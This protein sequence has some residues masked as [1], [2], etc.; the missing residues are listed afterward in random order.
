MLVSCIRRQADRRTRHHMMLD[1]QINPREWMN[2][3]PKEYQPW[4][5]DRHKFL[6]ERQQYAHFHHLLCHQVFLKDMLHLVQH[7]EPYTHIIDCRTSPLKMHRWV[8]H[9]GGYQ[10]MKLSMLFNLPRTSLLTCM[11]FI[12]HVSQTM[13]FLFPTTAFTLNRPV[14]NGRNSFTS[15]F[16]ITV[17]GQMNCL[18]SNTMT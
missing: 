5:F 13:L 10:G 6:Y 7:P 15:T 9:S 11:G 14:G 4:Y 16:T 2:W 17:A 1:G 3:H 12:N 18:G 8:P